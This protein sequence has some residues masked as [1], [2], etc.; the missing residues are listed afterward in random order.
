[1]QWR[2]MRIQPF[3]IKTFSIFPLLPGMI[4]KIQSASP[5]QRLALRCNLVIRLEKLKL[6]EV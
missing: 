4:V 1:M 5:R 6:S 2:P 3:L